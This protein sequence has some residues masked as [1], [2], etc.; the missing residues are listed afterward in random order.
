MIVTVLFV[1][2]TTMSPSGAPA[3]AVMR[4][5]GMRSVIVLPVMLAKILLVPTDEPSAAHESRLKIAAELHPLK[6][7]EP[8][9]VASGK[10]NDVQP[11]QPANT[12]NCELEPTQLGRSISVN[13]VQFWNAPKF[14]ELVP[15]MLG[16]YILPVSRLQRLNALDPSTCT[17]GMFIDFSGREYCV[18]E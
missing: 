16:R 3:L 9:P 2:S 4:D 15:T 6:K 10:L 12:E 17:S 11:V 1:V 18:D 8:T 5:V 7:L 14:S 13:P